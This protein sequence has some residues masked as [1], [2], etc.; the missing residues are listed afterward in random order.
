MPRSVTIFESGGQLALIERSL[1]RACGVSDHVMVSTETALFDALREGCDL[2]VINWT[3]P[4]EGLVALVRAVRDR[5]T[6]PDPFVAILVVSP[7]LN[8][9]NAAAAMNA[10]VTSLMRTPFSAADIQRQLAIV[11]APARFIDAPNY[12]G[13]DRRKGEATVTP[14]LEARVG[15]PC[16]ILE[17]DV[18]QAIRAKHREAFAAPDPARA[19]S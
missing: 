13:P 8:A 11:S 19:A 14:E 16:V 4:W 2:V 15:A 10:G 5:R 7:A 3:A 9:A 17:G 1:L 12:F 18:F 6:S